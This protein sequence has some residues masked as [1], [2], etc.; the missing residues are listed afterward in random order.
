MYGGAGTNA[1]KAAAENQNARLSFLSAGL[2]WVSGRRTIPSYNLTLAPSG[3]S[4]LAIVGEG[5]PAEW[6]AALGEFVQPTRHRLTARFPAGEEAIFALSK[7]YLRMILPEMAT[8]DRRALRR[9]TL[10]VSSDVAIP[11]SLNERV[12][13]YDARL[14]HSPLGFAGA[15]VSASQRALR[16]YAAL[17]AEH[18]KSR[19]VTALRALVDR[20][21]AMAAPPSIARRVPADDGALREQIATALRDAPASSSALLKRF[22]SAGIACEQHRFASLYRSVVAQ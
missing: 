22:R 11:A 2:G 19:S 5:T 21:L 20:D 18:P 12:I 15:Q 4:P 17:R 8:L 6:W 14:G 16:H 1:A 10:I 9:F 3:P 7:V 13:R